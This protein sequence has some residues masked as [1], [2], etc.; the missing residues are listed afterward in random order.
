MNV[1][2]LDAGV[3]IST[4]K[5]FSLHVNHQEIIVTSI[6]APFK[7]RLKSGLTKREKFGDPRLLRSLLS[8]S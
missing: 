6:L 3:S 8:I 4:V 5:L 2:V 7:S 1:E